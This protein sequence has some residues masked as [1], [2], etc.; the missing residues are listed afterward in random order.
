MVGFIRT[1]GFAFMAALFAPVLSAC[2]EEA[3]T[4]DQPSG[5]GYISEGDSLFIVFANP[6]DGK[7]E[8]FNSWYDAH[9]ADIVKLPEFVRGQRFRMQSRSGRPDPDFK[10]MIVYEIAGHPDEAL[11]ALGAA[12]KRGEAE[13]PNTEFVLKT[14]AM[15]YAPITEMMK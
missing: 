3:A 13:I 10:Y 11:A 7:E 14:N 15:A 1:F 5:S 4:N 9:M 2:A 6:V 12:V 8:A